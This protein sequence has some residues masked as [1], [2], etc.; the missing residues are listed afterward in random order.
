MTSS[1]LA[2]TIIPIQ[3]VI[4]VEPHETGESP[5]LQPEVNPH[6]QSIDEPHQK[7]E[8]EFRLLPGYKGRNSA[9]PG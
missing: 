1:R 7:N 4:E 3:G 2:F 6:P 5:P 8:Q 9:V